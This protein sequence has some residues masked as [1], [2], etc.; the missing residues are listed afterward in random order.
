[1]AILQ[2]CPLCNDEAEVRGD[3]KHGSFGITCRRCGHYKITEDAEMESQ[4]LARLRP[5]LSAATRQASENRKP[6]TLTTENVSDEARVHRETSPS[7]RLDKTL[8][9]LARTRPG[10]LTAIKLSH[11]FTVVS[12]ESSAEFS[13]YLDYLKEKGLI[14]RDMRPGDEFQ[15]MLTVP[16]RLAV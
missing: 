9:Y 7:T 5:F 15:C 3:F 11:D 8:L 13:L 6:I 1:M 4:T 14:T 12:A 2:T 10:Q 16:G